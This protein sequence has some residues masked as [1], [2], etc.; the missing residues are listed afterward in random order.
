MFHEDDLDYLD[1]NSLIIHQTITDDFYA[2]EQKKFCIVFFLHFLH[3]F[4]Y[5]T[6]KYHIL[7]SLNPCIFFF[8]AASI[9][10]LWI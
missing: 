7:S 9:K 6:M 10:I 3:F 4:S 5:R 8:N 1:E 2:G